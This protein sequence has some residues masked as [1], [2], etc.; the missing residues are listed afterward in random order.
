MKKSSTGADPI[1]C[2]RSSDTITSVIGKPGSDGTIT[3][4]GLSCSASKYSLGDL[5]LVLDWDSDGAGA[6]L[7]KFSASPRV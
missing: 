5:A 6:K 1:L 7:Y 3:S 4:K 2:A